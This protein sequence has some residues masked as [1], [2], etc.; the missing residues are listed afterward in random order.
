MYN[1][2]VYVVCVLLYPLQ[3]ITSSLLIAIERWINQTLL[4][5]TNVMLTCAQAAAIQGTFLLHHTY[6]C[7]HTLY[8]SR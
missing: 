3:M 6:G 4:T 2:Y 7:I 5:C 1:I 8:I